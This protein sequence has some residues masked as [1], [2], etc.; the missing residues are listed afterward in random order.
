MILCCVG[1]A[2]TSS[3]YFLSRAVVLLSNEGLEREG[4]QCKGS[5]I[6]PFWMSIRRRAVCVEDEEVIL[7]C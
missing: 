1:A 3:R 6:K 4:P 7:D 2:A 5:V